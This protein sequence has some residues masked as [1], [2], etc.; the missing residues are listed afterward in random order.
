M[1]IIRLNCLIGNLNSSILFVHRYLMSISDI[2]WF[3]MFITLIS[4]ILL[5]CGYTILLLLILFI[6]SVLCG[7]IVWFGNTVLGCLVLFY[8]YDSAGPMTSA[9][10]GYYYG[11][12]HN[13]ISFY[14]SCYVRFRSYF[15]IFYISFF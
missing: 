5:K 2:L 9:G 14:F 10:L 13:S 11:L 12:D 8:F 4:G 3:T 6:L 1:D 15:L 7:K